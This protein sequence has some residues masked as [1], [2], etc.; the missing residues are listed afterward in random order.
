MV[1]FAAL[2]CTELFSTDV[3]VVVVVGR[4]LDMVT[5]V[6]VGLIIGIEA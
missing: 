2:I 6:A 5:F 1:E 3:A 4:T